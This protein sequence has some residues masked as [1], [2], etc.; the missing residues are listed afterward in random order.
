MSFD[1]TVNSTEAAVQGSQS[2]WNRAMSFDIMSLR[3]LASVSSQS[4]WNRA[5]S[6]DEDYDLDVLAETSQSL[7]NRAMSFDPFLS[8]L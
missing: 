2:L 4:L 7:W 6:F 3:S 1:T 8:F 5:M